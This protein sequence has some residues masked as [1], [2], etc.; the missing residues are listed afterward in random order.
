[1]IIGFMRSMRFMH[2]TRVVPF[3]SPAAPCRLVLTVSALALSITLLAPIPASAQ[4]ALWQALFDGAVSAQSKGNLSEAEKQFS[5]ALKNA[6]SDA[7]IIDTAGRLALVLDQEGKFPEAKIEYEK[8]LELDKKLHG[9]NSAE[10]GVDLNSLALAC[11]HGG[12]FADAESYFKQSIAV[13]EKGKKNFELAGATTNLALLMQETARYDQVEPLF[14]QALTLYEKVGNQLALAGVLDLYAN[15][16]QLESR[17]SE[18]DALYNRALTV[19]ESVS[20]ASSPLVADTLCELGQLHCSQGDF[21]KGEQELRR[22]LGIARLTSANRS[23]EVNIATALADCLRSQDKHTEA[24]ALYQGALDLLQT[25]SGTKNA[26]VADALRNLAQN[27]VDTGDYVKA[28]SLL[29]KALA[30]DEEAYGALHPDLAVDLQT[31][32]LVYLDQGKYE[33]AEQL[34]KRALTLTETVLGQEHPNTATSLNNLAWLYYNMGKYDLAEPLVVR[35][36]TIRQKQF[37]AKHPLVAKNLSIYAVILSAEG[38]FDEAEPL[39]QRAISAEEEA[40]GVDHPDI[41]ENLKNLALLYINAGRTCEAEETL[42]KLLAR[43]EKAMGK[44]SAAVASDLEALSTVLKGVKKNPEALELLSR[45]QAIKAKLPGA[46]AAGTVIKPMLPSSGKTSTANVCRPVK[47]KWAL[48]V[49]ISNFKDAHINLRYAAKDATDFRNYLVNEAHFKPDHVCLLTDAQA[50]RENIVSNLGEKWLRRLANSD[51]LV[52]IYFSSHG[53]AAKPEAGATNFV[54]PYEGNMENLVFTGIPMQWL[55]AG[56]KDLVHCDRMVV[57][58]D[59]CH[60]GAATG[61]SKGLEREGGVDPSLI[62]VGDG[63]VV[64]ASSSASQTSWESQNYQNGVFTRR[65]IEGLKQKGDKTTIDEA[66]AY[67]KERVEEEVLR[68][69]AQVQTP[70]MEKRWQ[71]ADLPLAVTPA[72]P[73]PGLNAKPAN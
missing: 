34:Y 36:L 47:D 38:K 54:V 37:G 33:Q 42:R 53:S 28:E 3:L 17:Y 13:F 40:L 1:M 5:A 44:D 30:T 20:G 48:V 21:T 6:D 11:Q 50:T 43:D 49:G 26:K 29:V 10:V 18:A 35:A 66:F 14:K 71:G 32:G 19:R 72:S 25:S 22:A 23:R 73:R 55:T 45:A 2:F 62:S 8:T 9:Q 68:D 46:I 58:L 59:V 56:L 24:R 41:S 69:R 52:C 63:Q 27:Y 4:N 39:L 57:L 15:F 7:R 64:M 70:V 51:D 67:M 60:G 61:N 16:C 31:L 65:L 12:K